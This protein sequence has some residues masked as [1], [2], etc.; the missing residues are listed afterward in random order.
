MTVKFGFNLAIK[1][2]SV[3]LRCNLFGRL[4]DTGSILDMRMLSILVI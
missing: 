1:Y 3:I 2:K 4:T